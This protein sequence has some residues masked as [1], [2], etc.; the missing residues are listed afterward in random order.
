MA[1]LG[2]SPTVRER[3]LAAKFLQT[4][5]KQDRALASLAQSLFCTT[6]FSTVD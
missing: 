1:A 2:R 3:E 4:S 5:A 6:E